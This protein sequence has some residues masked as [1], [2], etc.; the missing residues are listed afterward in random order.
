MARPVDPLRDQPDHR[1]HLPRRQPP[2]LGNRLGHR[3]I[4]IAVQQ[5]RQTLGPDQKRRGLRLHV[6][7]P[8]FRNADVGADDLVDLLVQH[9][10]LEELHRRQAQPFL[11]GADGRG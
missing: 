9:A 8:L 5:R 7:D 2:H 11:L 3:R 4:A 1:P 6:A 10:L